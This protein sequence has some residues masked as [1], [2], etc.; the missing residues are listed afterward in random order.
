MKTFNLRRIFILMSAAGAVT[1]SNGASAAAFMLWEQDAASI[2]NYHAGTAAIADDASTAWYN[3]AGMI[4]LKNQQLVLGA[5]PI[6]TNF[7][8]SGTIGVNTIVSPF[9]G[10][11]A[12]P[13]PATAQ[14]GSYNTVPFGH[15]VA[16]IC[17]RVAIGMSID[18]PFGLETD[19]G[20][21]SFVRYSATLTQLK[22]VDFTP[23]IAV[24]ITDQFSIGAG[25]D[26]QRL[27]AELDQ[28][29]TAGVPGVLLLDTN[30][31]NTASDWGYGYRLG[32]L[33]QFTPDTRLGVNYHSKVTHH[34][35]GHSSLTGPLALPVGFSS[36]DAQESLN[37]FTN[38]TLPAT[39]S[40]SLFHDF[41]QTW[42]VMGSISYTQWSI[43][44]DLV[45]QNIAGIQNGINTNNLVV[46]I[47][48]HYHNAWNFAVGANYHPSNKWIIRTGVGF[49][50]TP[51]NDNYRN[52]QIPDSDRIALA[53]GA[54]Y[55]A[56]KT[57]G[58]DAG[59]THIF[60]MNTRIN[61]LTQVVGDE[62][63]TTNGSVSGNADVY[64][65]S[66]TWDMV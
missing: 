42:D 61:N 47:G 16:P 7:K 66:M 10:L 26:A 15:Y 59:W 40:L 37:A 64:G 38:V 53:L 24:K 5:D 33:F 29:A 18:V 55:Q 49:D 20:N 62:T 56:F 3:P 60:A 44:R 8:Y 2:G 39:T 4:R 54:H 36:T 6:L 13:T 32:A 14:G 27:T 48:Q 21:N 9:T 35:Q 34:A 1:L 63:V 45:L 41:C 19:Y 11:P 12:A 22:V 28:V 50:E 43:F 57:V 30:S 46:D 51:S 25:F 65:L 31:Q 58:F 17:D 52:L 23:S